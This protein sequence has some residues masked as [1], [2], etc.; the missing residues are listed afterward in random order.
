MRR[1]ILRHDLLKETVKQLDERYPTNAH[2]QFII[3]LISS[4]TYFDFQVPS[5]GCY[6]FLIYKLLQFIYKA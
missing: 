1:T 5:S 3:V 6:N 2:K 4:T